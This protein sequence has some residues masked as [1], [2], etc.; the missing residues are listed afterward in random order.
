MSSAI[1]VRRGLLLNLKD[2]IK[3]LMPFAHKKEVTLI[4]ETNKEAV[5]LCDAI[6]QILLYNIKVKEFHNNIPL[7]GLLERLEILTPPCII[8]R[9]T[10]G[11]VAC[12]PSL[13]SPLA[14]ARGW[15]RQIL[16]SNG[17][18]EAIQ[19]FLSQTN[20]MRSYYN[21]DSF[22]TQNEEAVA[23]VAVLRSLKALSFNFKV[24]NPKLNAAT[25]WIVNMIQQN[26][27]PIKLTPSGPRDPRHHSSA[28]MANQSSIS[29]NPSSQNSKS[30]A[31]DSFFQSFENSLVKVIGHVDAAAKFINEKIDS[32]LE[33]NPNLFNFD[34]QNNDN[35]SNNL[36]QKKR[37]TPFFGSSLKDLLLDEARCGHAN[38]NPMLGI[39]TQALK[40][41]NF[42]N[43][44]ITTP[45]LFRLRA[46]IYNV[47]ELHQL[48]ESEQG[49]PSNVDIATVSYV[50]FEWMNQLPEPLLGYEHYDAIL[51][52]LDLENDEHRQRN[53]NLLVQE[54]PWYNKPLLIR[55]VGL[56]SNC[57]KPENAAINKL[58]IIAVSV[59]STPF[60]L[61]PYQNTSKTG[62]KSTLDK[63]EIDRQQMAAA[64]IGS[65]TTEYLLSN[66]INIFNQIREDL[67]LKSNLLATKCGRIRKIQEDLQ[68]NFSLKSIILE[69]SYLGMI[70][71]LWKLLENAEDMMSFPSTTLENNNN[72]NNSEN[73][74]SNNN[75][76]LNGFSID[77]L[78]QNKRW[79]I[80]GFIN[81]NSFTSDIINDSKSELPLKEFAAQYGYMAVK[82]LIG[83]I[84]RYKTKAYAIIVDFC[85]NR[86][87]YCSLPQVVLR[88]VHF[89]ADALQLIATPENAQAPMQTLAKQP[90]WVLLN[91]DVCFQEV[92][93]MAMLS[94]DDAWKSYTDRIGELPD[95]ETYSQSL[96]KCRNTLWT[97]LGK[98]PKTL[99]NMWELWMKFRIIQQEKSAVSKLPVLQGY[100]SSNNDNNKISVPASATNNN[101]NILNEKKI[102]NNNN[103][104]N[105]KLPPPPVTSEPLFVID[106]SLNSKSTDEY[107]DNNINSPNNIK[108]NNNKN[109]NN[110]NYNN[111]NNNNNNNKEISLKSSKNDDDFILESLKFLD[112]LD[113]V[114][115]YSHKAGSGNIIDKNNDNNS[116]STSRSVSNDKG[117]VGTFQ[118][119]EGWNEDLSAKAMEVTVL[120]YNSGITTNVFGGS[121]ILSEK[122]IQQLESALPSSHQCYDWKLLY[123]LSIH[124]ASLATM[125]HNA[126]SIPNSLLVIRDQHDSI[127]GALIT[128]QIKI[129]DKYYGNGGICVWSFNSGSLKFY[130]WSYKN[131]YFLLTS[132][133]SIAL[134]GGGNFAIYL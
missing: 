19:F 7:W 51:S 125:L 111:N 9:N 127:F 55:V 85:Q 20:L 134:G 8:L 113:N 1:E 3:Q 94:F 76:E 43:N 72:N 4:D 33:N 79:E 38:L 126:K 110:N 57:I 101:A 66:Q 58:N 26:S 18:D 105:N 60:L 54:S 71:E 17:L 119:Q 123:R 28:Q 45:D 41:I 29:S 31:F 86:R 74:K 13:K 47:N 84:N 6:E 48:I 69:E 77:D 103:N 88:L 132:K 10:V 64:A 11:A 15:V 96:W 104:N 92:F 27:A 112:E 16:N 109:K 2:H 118:H 130:P 128:E 49:L 35:N 87:K 117:K 67:T 124:G 63:D 93:D 98:K 115:T 32:S 25:T 21:L 56:L 129:G 34:L 59:L 12:I 122:H 133:E 120:K 107:D 23:L 99:D 95:H 44:Y 22:F 65:T 114:T 106:S 91:D 108:T 36:S 46:S 82:S 70:R 30:N 53:L 75:N 131:A 83:F 73:S 100:S 97:I 121:S 50:F 62:F 116:T 40:M 80:C 37:L 14:K 5:L 42:I 52:C 89:T 68:L 61:R 78:L 102:N 81:T 24:D 90:S 39:P